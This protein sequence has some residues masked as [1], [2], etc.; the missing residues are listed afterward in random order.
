IASLPNV[1]RERARNLLQTYQNPLDA[2]QNVEN[3]AKAVHGLG[4]KTAKKAKSILHKPYK[5]RK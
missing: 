2:L 1:G 3:W 5:R 4:P